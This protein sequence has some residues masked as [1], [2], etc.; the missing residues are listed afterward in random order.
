MREEEKVGEG[1]LTDA[2]A[3]LN[4]QRKSVDGFRVVVIRSNLSADQASAVFFV[5]NFN[6]NIF[7]SRHKLRAF[8]VSKKVRF[9]FQSF[10]FSR[11]FRQSGRGHVVTEYADS[12]GALRTDIFNRLPQ[13]VAG[14]NNPHSHGVGCQRNVAQE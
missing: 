7:V 11:F 9:D 10:R 6:R 3:V 1:K 12:V 4:C 14:G 2:H 8:G 13:R 5:N